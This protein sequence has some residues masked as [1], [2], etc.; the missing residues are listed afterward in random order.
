MGGLEVVSVPEGTKFV[1][2]RSRVDRTPVSEPDD[3]WW[4]SSLLLLPRPLAPGAFP[5]PLPPPEGV[6]DEAAPA[7]EL[8]FPPPPP[9]PLESDIFL[10]VMCGLQKYRIF[11]YHIC[12]IFK[13]Q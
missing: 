5:P 4:V 12:P 6:V 7:E 10:L 1:I 11:D 9:P 3:I 13:L 2:S 8:L